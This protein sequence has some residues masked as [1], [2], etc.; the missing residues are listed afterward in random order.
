MTPEVQTPDEW[1]LTSH[2]IAV[3]VTADATYLPHVAAMLQS[4]M[5]VPRQPSLEV[6]LL[7]PGDADV[8]TDALASAL[9]DHGGCLVVHRVGVDR[10]RGISTDRFS[11]TAWFR[12]LAPD[13]MPDHDRALHLDGDMLVHAS[14]EGLWNSDLD[15]NLFAAVQNPLYP[16]MRSASDRLGLR[17]G[18]PY[19]NSGVLLMD[20]KQMR[21]GTV[22]ALIAYGRAHPDNPWPEQDALAAVCNDRWLELHPRWNVQSTVMELP[23]K[24]LPWDRSLVRE[25]RRDPAVRHFS[26]P[27]KPWDGWGSRATV[28]SYAAHRDRAGY[29]MARLPRIKRQA[30]LLHHL[31]MSLRRRAMLRIVQS[32]GAS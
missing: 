21:Q 8:P 5:A 1:A 24:H 23:S 25:A 22:D 14:L 12:V 29:P 19:L 26:G 7:Q 13:L 27:L 4:A 17:D 30:A 20:L 16:W 31:P 2:R 10:L 3:T 11:I 15:G 32:R 28:E 18:A 6:H 9:R